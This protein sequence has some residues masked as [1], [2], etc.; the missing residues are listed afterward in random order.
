MAKI[1]TNKAKKTTKT[2]KTDYPVEGKPAETKPSYRA[3]PIKN[4][5]IVEKTW[6]DKDGKYQ[7]EKMYHEQ[8][9]FDEDPMEKEEED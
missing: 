5:W 4:G 8:N 3:E 1:K 7:C 2:V 6:T 9:P